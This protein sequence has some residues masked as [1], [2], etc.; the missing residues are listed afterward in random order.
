M[1]PRDLLSLLHTSKANM[2]AGCLFGF[3]FTSSQEIKTV[4]QQLLCD[5]SVRNL[6]AQIS[7]TY[8]EHNYIQKIKLNPK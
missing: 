1:F 8:F 5:V 2:S 4:T 7:V 3:P 6:S